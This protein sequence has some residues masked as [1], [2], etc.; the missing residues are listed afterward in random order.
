MDAPAGSDCSH[1]PVTIL[2]FNPPLQ[3][4]L[5]PISPPWAARATGAHPDHYLYASLQEAVKNLLWSSAGREVVL[6]A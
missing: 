4:L 6:G 5:L 1:P 3:P 2:P